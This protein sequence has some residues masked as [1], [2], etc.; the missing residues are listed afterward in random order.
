M[1]AK[2]VEKTLQE[3]KKCRAEQRRIELEGNRTQDT[4]PDKKL[5]FHFGDNGSS[6]E[7]INDWDDFEDLSDWAIPKVKYVQASPSSWTNQWLFP[8]YGS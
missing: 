8:R 6:L 4:P 7:E 5:K 2:R 1:A 3:S